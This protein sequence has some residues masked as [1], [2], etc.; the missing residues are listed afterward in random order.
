MGR[1]HRRTTERTQLQVS[2]S[3]AFTYQPLRA[4][5]SP[6]PLSDHEPEA[7]ESGRGL[8]SIFASALLGAAVLPL[9]TTQLL[10]RPLGAL[11]AVGCAVLGA[12]LTALGLALLRYYLGSRLPSGNAGNYLVQVDICPHQAQSAEHMLSALHAQ[13]IQVLLE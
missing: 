8:G 6:N 7:A 13:H 12:N 2:L 1:I 9:A 5:I 11:E 4:Q 3:G 10:A